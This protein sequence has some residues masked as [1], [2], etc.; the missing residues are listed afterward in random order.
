METE[1][2]IEAT[3]PKPDVDADKAALASHPA[4][5][6]VSPEQILAQTKA[7]PVT[8]VESDLVPCKQ[9][10]KLLGPQ[11]MLTHFCDKP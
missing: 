6:T 3:V 9:C 2:I 10:G 8:P 4:V 5:A 7:P 1:T 11:D